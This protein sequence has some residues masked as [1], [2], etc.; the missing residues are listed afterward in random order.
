MTKRQEAELREAH[1]RASRARRWATVADLRGQL[2]SRRPQQRLF[3]LALMRR[4]AI[5][6]HPLQSY[7]RLA[8][9]LVDDPNNNCRWQ[10]LIIL[11]EFVA[12]DPEKVW[13]IV[14]KYGDHRD[15][16]MRTGVATILLEHLLE[17]HFASYWPRVKRMVRRSPSRFAD[18]LS[19]AW[20]LGR[21]RGY[22]REVNQ[23]LKQAAAK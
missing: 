8:L 7:R 23:V 12:S 10:A 20:L 16:D 5:Q 1:E 4:Q 6:R 9:P 13:P 11:G 18:T 2:N 17:R 14:R 3:A 19:R 22:S 21:A 15:P